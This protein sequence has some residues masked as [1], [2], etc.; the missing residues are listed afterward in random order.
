MRAWSPKPAALVLT[1]FVPVSVASAQWDASNEAG[2]STTATVAPTPPPAPAEMVESPPLAQSSLQPPEE[3]G[4][5]VG[6]TWALQIGVPIFLDV[7]RDIV[8]AG[9]DI[10]FFGGADFGYFIIGGA[11]GMGWNPVDLNASGISGL[12]GRSPVTR[13]FLSIP[14]FRVQIPDLK[15]VL[16]YISGSFDMNFW[17]FRETQVVCSVYYCNQSSVYRFTPG[18]TGRGGLAFEVNHGIYVDL[19]LRYSFTGKGD[20]FAQSRWWLTPYVG[21]LVRRRK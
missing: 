10:G 16:P 19:G 3:K 20:F 4:L 2:T 14:E 18:F 11:A 1:L 15:V 17:N 21:V 13:L 8:K 7:D 9:A 5:E 6:F 12:N